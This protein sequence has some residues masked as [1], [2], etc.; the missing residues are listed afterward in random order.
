VLSD[1]VAAALKFALAT[2]AP[3]LVK[4]DMA[5]LKKVVVDVELGGI[6]QVSFDAMH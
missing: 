1:V 4:L 5:L 3:T 6:G 2:V